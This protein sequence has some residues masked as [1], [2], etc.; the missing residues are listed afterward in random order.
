MV[1]FYISKDLKSADVLKSG[2]LMIILCQ[3]YTDNKIYRFDPL[4]A[5]KHSKRDSMDYIAHFRV[6]VLHVKRKQSK[7]QFKLKV[8]QIRILKVWTTVM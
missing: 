7:Q 6:G 4:K 2:S 1:F 3:N 8:W 5:I